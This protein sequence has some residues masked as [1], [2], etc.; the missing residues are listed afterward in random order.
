MANTLYI[1]STVPEMF[2][3]AL[4]IVIVRRIDRWQTEKSYIETF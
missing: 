2:A 3:A 1:A 4:L